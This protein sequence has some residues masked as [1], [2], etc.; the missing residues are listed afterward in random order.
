VLVV[1]EYELVL[2]VNTLGNKRWLSVTS[3]LLPL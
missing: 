1:W 2:E 3:T